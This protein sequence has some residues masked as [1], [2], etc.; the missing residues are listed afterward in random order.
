MNTRQL[1][2]ASLIGGAI[3]LILTNVPILNLVNCLLCAGFWAG[4]LIAVWFY[5]RQTGSLTLGQGVAIGALAAVWSGLIGMLLSF[6][7]LAGLEAVI[8]SYARFV[9]G[10]AS[11][12]QSLGL[13]ESTILNVVGVFGEIAIGAV[14]GLIGGAIFRTKAPQGGSSL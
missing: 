13:V 5:R 3:N 7:G 9:P 4:P 1:L 12:E 14:A 10:E 8:Q 2:I 6:L 11:L